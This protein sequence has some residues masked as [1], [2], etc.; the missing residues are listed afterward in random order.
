LGTDG[1]IGS[2]CPHAIHQFII[3]M[4]AGGEILA[5]AAQGVV[6]SPSLEVFQ[7]HGDVALKDVVMATVGSS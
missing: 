1:Q 5:Q 6:W 4:F 3:L 2:F 7:S